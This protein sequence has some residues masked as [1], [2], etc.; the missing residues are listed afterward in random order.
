[1]P[2]NKKQTV[3]NWYNKLK[4]DKWTDCYLAHC[5]IQTFSINFGLFIT[6]HLCTFLNHW[7]VVAGKDEVGKNGTIFVLCINSSDL[8]SFKYYQSFIVTEE[9]EKKVIFCSIQGAR[10]V[11]GFFVKVK[12]NKLFPDLCNRNAFILLLTTSLLTPTPPLS[13]GSEKL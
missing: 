6:V 8:I 13:I 12:R 7:F 11:F 4:L 10:F 5:W 1:M 9:L 3:F 2:S